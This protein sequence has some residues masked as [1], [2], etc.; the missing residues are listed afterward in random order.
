MNKTTEQK[1]IELVKKY[2]KKAGRLIEVVERNGYDIKS[3]N[4]L[5]EVKGFKSSITSSN[6]RD[7]YGSIDKLDRSKY[8]IY[9]VY[10]I[11]TKHPKLLKIPPRLT[12]RKDVVKKNPKKYIVH[13]LRI[14]KEFNLKTESI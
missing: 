13:P 6:Y 9:I 7:I 5:I 3:R 2:E 8:W 4:R 10:D 1:S 11:N 12:K 14:K